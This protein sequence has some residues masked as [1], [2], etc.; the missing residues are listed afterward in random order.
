MKT[1]HPLHK[2]M[3]EEYDDRVD[4]IVSFSNPTSVKIILVKK[5]KKYCL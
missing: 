5:N 1:I 2:M 4:G 3:L